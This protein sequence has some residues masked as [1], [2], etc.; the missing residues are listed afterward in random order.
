MSKDGKNAK[1]HVKSCTKQWHK[2]AQVS[3]LVREMVLEQETS[4]PLRHSCSSVIFLDVILS[5]YFGGF[6]YNQEMFQ[7]NSDMC[8]QFY[9]QNTAAILMRIK[10]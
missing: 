1:D 7:G 5:K 9:R 2:E 3:R 10:N 6:K 4:P 8:T